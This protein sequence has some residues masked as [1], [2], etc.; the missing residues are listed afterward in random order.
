MKIDMCYVSATGRTKAMAEAIAA[1]ILEQVSGC[2]V[3]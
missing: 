3:R 2:E 1:G